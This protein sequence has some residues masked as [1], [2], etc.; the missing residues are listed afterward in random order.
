MPKDFAGRNS[1]P[2]KGNKSSRPSPRKVSPAPR[3]LFHGPSFSSG[4]II[5]AL[6]VVIAAYAPDY[7]K[8]QGH[9]LALI[10]ESP[11]TQAAPEMIFEFPKLLRDSEVPVDTE[12]YAVPEPAP[13]SQPKSYAI[14]AASFRDSED[15]DQ[16]R[17]QLLL[18]NLPARVGYSRVGEQT[19]FRVRVGPFT[20][21]VEADR[22]MTKL[23]Q[24]GLSAI[25]M[26]NHN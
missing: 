18:E 10:Q 20:R 7:L 5:G 23:R 16:L 8:S 4:A 11:T 22:A 19:W 12:T 17:A 3:V 21:K 6:V 9:D 2:R 25:W 13:G 15:A 24:R 14:Q 1:K 26:N